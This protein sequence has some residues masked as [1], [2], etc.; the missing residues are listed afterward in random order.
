M[1]DNRKSGAGIIAMTT[2]GS[3]A[4]TRNRAVSRGVLTIRTIRR[5]TIAGGVGCDTF[6]GWV[7][8]PRASCLGLVFGGDKQ[9]VT[10]GLGFLPLLEGGYMPEGE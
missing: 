6:T 3:G 1:K 10:F 4:H 5:K 9:L 2:K 7:F 8:R